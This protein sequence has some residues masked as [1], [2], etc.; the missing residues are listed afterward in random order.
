[1]GA[2]PV[3]DFRRLSLT[4]AA[5]EAVAANLDLAAEDRRVAAGRQIVRESRAVLRP[6]VSATGVAEQ[7]DLDERLLV[8]LER[9]DHTA[10]GEIYGSRFYRVYRALL[11]A[12]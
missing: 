2:A 5:H 11:L 4:R 9:A 10:A 6:R 8:T 12:S 7:I 3:A 1:M